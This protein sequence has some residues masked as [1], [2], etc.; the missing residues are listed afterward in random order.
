MMDEKGIGL[1]MVILIA[2]LPGYFAVNTS[3]DLV[4]S[5]RKL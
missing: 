5:E 1:V 2:F 4:K 3:L